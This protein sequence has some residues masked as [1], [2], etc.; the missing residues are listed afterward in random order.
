MKLKKTKVFALLIIIMIV[1]NLISSDY[2][3][4]TYGI[5]KPE[6]IGWNTSIEFN[7]YGIL[8]PYKVSKFKSEISKAYSSFEFKYCTIEY[9]RMVNSALHNE[10]NEIDFNIHNIDRKY[11]DSST[12]VLVSG[13]NISSII[14]PFYP[15]IG[16]FVIVYNENSKSIEDIIF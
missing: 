14:T 16:Y 7:N 3:I 2:I 1:Y 15:D 13:S 11:L 9:K 6:W 10:K 5:F 12:I 8:N 4:S